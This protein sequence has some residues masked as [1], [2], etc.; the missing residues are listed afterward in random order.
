M[1][2]GTKDCLNLFVLKLRGQRVVQ[3]SAEVLREP[4]VEMVDNYE[5]DRTIS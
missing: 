4:A 1:A 2:A 5:T 3:A